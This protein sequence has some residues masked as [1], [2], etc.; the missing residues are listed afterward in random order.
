M[1]Y[2][3]Y[4]K[5]TIKGLGFKAE[6]EKKEIALANANAIV[7]SA[8]A[9]VSAEEG[10]EVTAKLKYGGEI[11]EIIGVVKSVRHSTKELKGGWPVVELISKSWKGIQCE[12]KSDGDFQSLVEAIP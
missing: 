12:F 2:G 1:I 9:L 7:I 10:N 3:F 8:E 5:W 11:L 6:C 4:L